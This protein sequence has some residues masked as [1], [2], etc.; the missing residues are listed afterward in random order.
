[1]AERRSRT[2]APTLVGLHEGEAGQVVK[3]EHP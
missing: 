3:S 2:S 1:M